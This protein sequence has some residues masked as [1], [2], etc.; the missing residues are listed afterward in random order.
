[1]E[2]E[3]NIQEVICRALGRPPAELAPAEAAELLRNLVHDDPVWLGYVGLEL[4][5]YVARI[6][7][8]RDARSHAQAVDAVH[9]LRMLVRSAEG[10]EGAPW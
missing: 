9:G 1:M 6:V 2:Q 4:A 5:E 8:T 7:A 3:P 10:R